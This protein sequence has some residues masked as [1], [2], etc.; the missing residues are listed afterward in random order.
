MINTHR[1]PAA[2]LCRALT[3][4]ALLQSVCVSRSSRAFV[5]PRVAP[6]SRLLVSAVFPASPDPLLLTT[7]VQ[8]QSITPLTQ[9]ALT[10]PVNGQMEGVR[11]DFSA[12]WIFGSSRMFDV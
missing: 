7:P 6:P 10:N 5:A 1:Q 9:P 12:Q 4:G 3:R 11:D 8:P 2:T